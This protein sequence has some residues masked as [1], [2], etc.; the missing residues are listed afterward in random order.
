MARKEDRFFVT[1][2]FLDWCWVRSSIYKLIIFQ[3]SISVHQP[4]HNHVRAYI[5]DVDWNIGYQLIRSNEGRGYILSFYSAWR[6]KYL[7]QE[8]TKNRVAGF[9]RSGCLLLVAH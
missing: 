4:V 2:P 7:R 6:F 9:G 1:F 5:M 3:S 8:V